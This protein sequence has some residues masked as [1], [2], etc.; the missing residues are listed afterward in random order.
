MSD[1]EYKP[2]NSSYIKLRNL[3]EVPPGTQV[4]VAKARIAIARLLKSSC[5]PLVQVFGQ[6]T[7]VCAI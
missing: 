7:A 5:P 1:T 3:L 4:R 6:S 2:F